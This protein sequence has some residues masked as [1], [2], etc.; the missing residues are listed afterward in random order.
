[1][2]LLPKNPGTAN[3]LQPKRTHTNTEER[4]RE[5]NQ[6][7]NKRFPLASLISKANKN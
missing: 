6:Q 2:S 5:S 4:E 3:H 1:V 7:T